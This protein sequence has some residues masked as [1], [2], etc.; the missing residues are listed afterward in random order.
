MENVTC[1]P[2]VQ[3]DFERYKY[4]RNQLLVTIWLFIGTVLVCYSCEWK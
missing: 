4:V 2:H 3:T 1:H